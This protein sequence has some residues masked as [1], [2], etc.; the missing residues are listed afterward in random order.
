[1]RLHG[2]GCGRS[3]VIHPVNLGHLADDDEFIAVGA[4]G[5]VIIETVALLGI[6]AD[7]VGGLQHRAGDRVVNAAARAGDFGTGRVHDLLLGVVHQHHAFRHPLADH[8]P[9]R[10]RAVD[11]IGL[12]PVVVLDADLFGVDFAQPDNRAAA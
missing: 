10:D 1:M 3:L 8:R 2:W 5:A 11:V 6:A 7:H 9:R 4:D 12:D